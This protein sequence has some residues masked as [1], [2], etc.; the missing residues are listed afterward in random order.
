MDA[1]ASSPDVARRIVVGYT[2]NESGADALALATRLATASEALLDVVMVLP[3]EA[4]SST[5]PSDVGYERHLKARSREWLSEASAGLDGDVA[6]SLHVRYAESFAEG[7]IAAA[8]EFGASLI[9]VGAA[10]GGILGRSRIGSVANE[11]LHSSDV[12]VALAPSGSR[13]LAASVGV[14]RITAAL[15]TRPGAGV[16]LDAAV[17][18][19]KSLR[20]PL[21]LLSLVPIDLPAGMDEGLAELTSEAHAD[22]VLAAARQA[23]PAGTRA[24]AEV[25]TGDTIEEAVR[26]LDWHEGELVLVAS[27][28]LAKPSHLFLGSTAS[29]MLR[30]LPVPMIVVPRSTGPRAHAPKAAS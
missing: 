17:R 12:P 11:L 4:R 28:R 1:A 16:L 2:A 27:S 3:S 15:G 25:A 20:A 24:T 26:S 22:E 19:T 18:L 21:R 10:R 5:V 14:T 7:L 23:L 29:K 6:Q 8:H 13:E 9:V 30:E